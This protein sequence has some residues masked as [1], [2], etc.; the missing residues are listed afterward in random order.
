MIALDKHAKVYI[1]SPYYKTG[2]PKS[3]HQLAGILSKK[4]MDVYMLYYTGKEIR[5]VDHLLYPECG[6][7]IAYEVEDKETNI[8]IVSE[9]DSGILLPYE[10]VKKVI[11]WLSLDFYL[12]NKVVYR[13][14]LSMYKK[15]YPK[16]LF[17]FIILFKILFKRNENRRDVYIKDDKFFQHVYHMY[18]CEYVHEFLKKKN[19]DESR[20][21]YL[22]GP[23]EDSYLNI[24]QDDILTKKKNVIIYNP[25]KH[26][27]V[28][29]EKIE[30]AIRGIDSDIDFLPIRSMSREEVYT[31]LSKAKLYMDFG[32]FPG[33]ERMPRE[34]VSLYCNMIV[35]KMGSAQNA[36]DVPIP[37]KFK[38]ITTNNNIKNI[39]TLAVDMIRNYNVYLN[40]FDLYRDKVKK[41]I[42]RFT[43]D[44][45]E[46]FD[47]E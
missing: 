34:A 16:I 5:K 38:F 26:N 11:W 29:F 33:P 45:E 15:G 14:K 18:N 37:D 31:A 39:A 28:Y 9:Y 40:E 20:M 17:P 21:H 46:I 35:A 41:Q 24:N 2:G 42:L 47:M 43:N 10:N 3:L 13:T 27:K 7:K 23:L 8:I 44:I 30:K 1:V 4:N 19:V 6:A 32:Y 12:T 36:E 25:A 22:C